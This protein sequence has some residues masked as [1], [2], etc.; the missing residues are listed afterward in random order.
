MSIEL[1]DLRCFLAIA[2]M[3]SVTRAAEHPAVS[4]WGG[5]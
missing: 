4:A 3:L 5:G 2:D 1:R